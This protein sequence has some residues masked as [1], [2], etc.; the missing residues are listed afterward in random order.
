MAYPGDNVAQVDCHGKEGYAISK[1]TS[2]PTVIPIDQ[3]AVWSLDTLTEDLRTGA[4]VV[5]AEIEAQLIAHKDLVDG[6][7]RR[8]VVRHGHLPEREVPTGIGPIPVCVP[9]ARDRT[10]DGSGGPIQ[11]RFSLLPRTYGGRA[12]WNGSCLGCT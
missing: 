6:G 11:F 1:H 7:G 4:Q 8:R 3:A 2:D 10:L 5:E 12:R 9:R